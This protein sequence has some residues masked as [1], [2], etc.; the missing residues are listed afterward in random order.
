MA[1]RTVTPPRD[2]EQGEVY[3]SPSLPA[4]RLE[5]YSKILVYRTG[6]PDTGADVIRVTQ[7]YSS[8]N[9][10]TWNDFGGFTARGGVYILR[11]GA[12]LEYHT[13]TTG[14]FPDADNT[15]RKI[16]IRIE[17]LAP[18]RTNVDLETSETAQATA[19]ITA[20]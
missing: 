6:W 20:G 8:D 4:G 2:F 7:L 1:V 9:G 18:L 16:K 5:R 17:A 3:E 14:T 10:Q 19:K 15:Q 12:V 11:G 13:L